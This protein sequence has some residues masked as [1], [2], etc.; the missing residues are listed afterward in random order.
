M[1]VDGTATDVRRSALT[2]A[3]IAHNVFGMNTNAKKLAALMELGDKRVKKLQN[4]PEGERISR[5]TMAG[6]ARGL[7]PSLEN[8]ARY[9]KA[10]K[11]PFEGWL[12]EDK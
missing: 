5:T 7:V 3:T 4:A 2:L 10:L 1:S 12:T 11:L 6:N 8:A 9:K